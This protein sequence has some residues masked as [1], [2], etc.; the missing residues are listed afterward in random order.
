MLHIK[1]KN[2]YK[3]NK[4]GADQNIFKIEISTLIQTH[5]YK[6]YINDNTST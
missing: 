3:T 4:L 5:Q 2:V 1:I 6:R